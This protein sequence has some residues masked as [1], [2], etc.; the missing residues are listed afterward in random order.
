MEIYIDKNRSEK[1]LH[2][3][4][5][6]AGGLTTRRVGNGANTAH[7]QQACNGKCSST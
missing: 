3:E 7:K 2:D 6:L 1:W 4:N 5:E